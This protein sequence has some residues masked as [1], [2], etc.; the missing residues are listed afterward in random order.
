MR[1]IYRFCNHYS[2]LYKLHFHPTDLAGLHSLRAT[3]LELLTLFHYLSLRPNNDCIL[4]QYNSFFK[5]SSG[6][7]LLLLIY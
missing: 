5:S 6:E 4:Q 7:L 2:I 3:S 1:Q